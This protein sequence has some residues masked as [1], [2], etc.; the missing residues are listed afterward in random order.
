M[1]ASKKSFN[2]IF[3]CSIFLLIFALLF[4]L[5]TT[6]ITA[7]A[8]HIQDSTKEITVD[9]D[10]VSKIVKLKNVNVSILEDGRIKPINNPESLT[11][12]ERTATMK[13][14]KF[15]DDEIKSFPDGLINEILADGGVKVELTQEDFRHTYTDLQGNDHIVTPETMDEVNEIKLKDS[16]LV[17]KKSKFDSGV[18]TLA[19]EKITDGVFTGQ[20]ILTYLGKTSNGLEFE[21]NYRTAWEFS[22]MPSLTF[23]DSIATSWQNHTTSVSSTSDYS[24]YANGN[25]GHSNKVTLDRSSIAGTKGSI[26]LQNAPG[27]HYG[28]IQDKVRIPVSQSGTTG[29]FASAYGHSHFPT[30]IGGV[31][32]NIGGFGSINFGSAKGDKWDWRNTFK[33][34]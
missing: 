33:I 9:T 27:R 2:M 29:S 24:R 26:D 5:N 21:Y 18:D 12:E 28:Y 3:R 22:S 4:S 7:N 1:I 23:V 11:K 20:G 31:S 25:F 19:M 32:I 30:N 6:K 16:Q 10:K 8:M 15:S 34:N 14:M 17:A 13:L